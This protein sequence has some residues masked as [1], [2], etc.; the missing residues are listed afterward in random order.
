MYIHIRH[1]YTISLDRDI[2]ILNNVECLTTDISYYRILEDSGRAKLPCIMKDTTIVTKLKGDLKYDINYLNLLTELDMLNLCVPFTYGD[3][4][5]VKPMSHNIY[6]TIGAN[7]FIENDIDVEERALFFNDK[8]SKNN[9]TMTEQ[10]RKMLNKIYGSL[11]NYASAYLYNQH[12]I[13]KTHMI[14]FS[15]SQSPTYIEFQ[16][17][18]NPLNV[19]YVLDGECDLI[20]VHPDY[21]NKSFI[22]EDY[23]FFRFYYNKNVFENN[24]LNDILGGNMQGVNKIHCSAGDVVLLPCNWFISIKLSEK[25]VLLNES[26][27]TMTSMVSLIPDYVKNVFYRSTIKIVPNHISNVEEKEVEIQKDKEEIDVSID[28]HIIAEK[29][30]V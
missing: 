1:Y 25:C 28:T 18:K 16:T 12:I 29:G 19:F 5:P 6:L 2:I 26:V 14:Y 21:I 20:I 30:T 9:E 24:N 3:K 27:S 22:D 15:N 13:R 4:E 17:F 23:V 11:G 10:Q 7:E 8:L